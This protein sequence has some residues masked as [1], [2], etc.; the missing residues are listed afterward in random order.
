MQF[1]CDGAVAESGNTTHGMCQTT[2]L[3]HCT[4]LASLFCQVDLFCSASLFLLPF[5]YWKCQGV[6]WDLKPPSNTLQ[7]FR[8]ANGVTDKD[9]S[10][11]FCVWIMRVYMFILGIWHNFKTHNNM[12]LNQFTILELFGWWRFGPFLTWYLHDTLGNILIVTMH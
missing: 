11:G 1:T 6:V 4:R 8:H 12:S 5:H 3:G 10:R 7:S 2:V 9:S